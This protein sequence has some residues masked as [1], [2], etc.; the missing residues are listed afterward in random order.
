MDAFSATNCSCSE[1]MVELICSIGGVDRR[2]IREEHDQLA[3]GDTAV[4]HRAKAEVEDERRPGR[5]GRRH[6]EVEGGL[7]HRQG[8]P[9]ID[10]RLA[11][12][13]EASVLVTLAAERDDDAQHAHRL[14]HDRERLPLEA[15]HPLQPRHDSLAVEAEGVVDERKDAES[16]ERHLP[17]DQDS[18]HDHAD[19]G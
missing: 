2:D 10:G 4:E 7:P 9:C 17:V 15:L 19:E 8:N 11:L 12:L 18:D 1:P 16:D 14:V 6:R 5:R 3:D 13:A